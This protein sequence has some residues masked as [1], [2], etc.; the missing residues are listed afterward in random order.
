MLS[1]GITTVVTLRNA[2]NCV[3]IA[4]VGQWRVVPRY[5]ERHLRYLPKHL[6]GIGP[7]SVIRDDPAIGIM[8]PLVW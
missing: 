7:Y 1:T 5:S 3:G 4:V 8:T 6:L 2:G